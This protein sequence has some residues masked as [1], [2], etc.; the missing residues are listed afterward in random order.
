[1]KRLMLVVAAMT[2]VSAFADRVIMKSGSVLTGSGAVV[3]GDKV[4]FTSDDLGAVELPADKVA[5]VETAERIGDPETWRRVSLSFAMPAEAASAVVH[6][7]A[8]G[9]APDET[10]R[11]DDAE[12]F[13]LERGK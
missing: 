4:K 11:Y 13:L 2:A 9:L 10:L 6:C 3:A 12:L 5:F 7:N 8:N 1:M